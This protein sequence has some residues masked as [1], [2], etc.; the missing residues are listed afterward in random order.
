MPHE[1][2]YNIRPSFLHH[3]EPVV[4][5][6]PKLFT[7]LCFTELQPLTSEQRHM[8]S[9]SPRAFELKTPDCLKGKRPLCQRT[10]TSDLW[11]HPCINLCVSG[12][13]KRRETSESKRYDMR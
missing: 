7:K 6:A 3:L 12:G 13:Q 5:C 11:P 1:W 10:L 8:S 4:T 9:R 2:R